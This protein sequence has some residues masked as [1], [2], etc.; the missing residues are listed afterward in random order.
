MELEEAVS[1]L[2]NHL[3]PLLE[4]DACHLLR[5]Y[6]RV[7]AENVFA[8]V[9]VPPF[10]K[11]AMDGYAVRSEDVA[12]AGKDTP[13]SLRVV[14][15][16]FA[17]ETCSV[18]AEKGTCVRVMTGSFIPDGYDA[19]VKQE[20]TDYGEK[21]VRI[22]SS[23]KKL[24]NYCATGEDI[25]KGAL[26]LKEGTK[27]TR[28]EI[29]LLASVGFDS[30]SV[31]KPVRFAIL[32]T[33]SELTEPGRPLS[34]GKIY[35]SIGFMLSSALQEAGQTVSMLKIVEDNSEKITAELE[36]ALAESDFVITTGGV[37]VGKKDLLPSVL[38]SLGAETIFSRVSVQ[39]GTPTIASFLNGK[40]ILSLSGNPYAALVHFDLYVYH[41]LSVLLGCPAFEP[42]KKIALL[43]SPYDKVNAL[44]R[45]VRA[46]YDGGKVTLPSSNHASSVISNMGACNCYID[47]PPSTPL[48]SGDS[49][50]VILMKN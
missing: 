14:A 25:Q 11:S 28:A 45:L 36:K 21:Y 18:T 31:K 37:S 6:G 1:V 13:V 30:V 41:A 8:P 34:D 20:N 16:I 5:S 19:V 12:A 43:A 24:Q 44:R 2:K 22:F 17:G 35:S 10:P 40:V 27:I 47:I 15:E 32:C 42:E 7:A 4:T 48:K 50:S 33:G 9:S 38:S 29:G 26:I 23:V 46:R 3:S 39:P 49:V